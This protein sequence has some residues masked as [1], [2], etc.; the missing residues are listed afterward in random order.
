MLKPIRICVL[1]GIA[2]GA[3]ASGIATAAPATNEPM[4]RERTE[5]PRGGDPDFI[6]QQ[7]D[8]MMA[9]QSTLSRRGGDDVGDEAEDVGDD[10]GGGR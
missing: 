3:G 1:L 9:R 5:G 7:W 8:K 6:V 2:L 10:H 4:A